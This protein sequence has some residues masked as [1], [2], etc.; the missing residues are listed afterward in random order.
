MTAMDDEL[1]RLMREVERPD[2]D[3]LALRFGV[4]VSVVLDAWDVLVGDPGAAVDG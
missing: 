3:A 4:D 1:E 2:F